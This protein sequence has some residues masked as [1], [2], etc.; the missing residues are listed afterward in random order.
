MIPER[1]LTYEF[2]EQRS[3]FTSTA[4]TGFTLVPNQRCYFGANQTLKGK[5]IIAI[6]VMSIGIQ[7]SP[8]PYNGVNIVFPNGLTDFVL[9]MVDK[10]GNEVVKNYPVSD[11]YRGNN[12]GKTRVFDFIPN[13]ESSYIMS[14]QGGWGNWQI[15]FNFHTVS[16]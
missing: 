9:T 16:W 6:D 8:I 15:L 3:M 14:T 11:L 5:R 7:A 13:I 4:Q 10:G 1:N 2:I 12:S